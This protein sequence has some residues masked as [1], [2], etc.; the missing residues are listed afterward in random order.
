MK[1]M[2]I[3]FDCDTISNQSPYWSGYFKLLM[4]Q[5]CPRSTNFSQVSGPDFITWL[6]S[7]VEE[8]AKTNC[9][10]VFRISYHGSKLIVEHKPPEEPSYKIQSVFYG[11]VTTPED[12][13]PMHM[14][15]S[16]FYKCLD[17]LP[18]MAEDHVSPP[19]DDQYYTSLSDDDDPFG[20]DSPTWHNI[21]NRMEA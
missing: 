19:Y 3:I 9:W 7:E 20:G 14:M 10:F 8:A 16:P 18:P 6:R 17:L 13:M 4:Y 2:W 21:M 11:Y 1:S 15:G 12:E 5:Y